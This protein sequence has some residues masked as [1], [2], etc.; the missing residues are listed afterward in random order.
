MT[1]K[2]AIISKYH[3]SDLEAEELIDYM[4]EQVNGGSDPES[5]L[6]DEGFEP[7]YVI[8]LLNF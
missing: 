8:D 6:E 7:D 2:E 5:V 1:L 3:C 4:M